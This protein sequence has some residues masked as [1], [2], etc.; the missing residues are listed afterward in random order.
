[1][2]DCPQLNGEESS[3]SK[4]QNSKISSNR[5]F[6]SIFAEAKICIEFELNFYL[7]IIKH[8]FTNE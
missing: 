2:I 8:R 7:S 4:T 6:D 5:V 3:F 1:M